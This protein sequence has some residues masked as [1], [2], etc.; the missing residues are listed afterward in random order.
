MLFIHQIEKAFIR[1]VYEAKYAHHDLYVFQLPA[2]EG[3]KCRLSFHIVGVLIRYFEILIL[4]SVIILYTCALHVE[5]M[6][7]SQVGD[8]GAYCHSEFDALQSD[9]NFSTCLGIFLPGYTAL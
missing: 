6:H 3:C 1:L 7:V 4:F 8:N 9:M 5:N 2:N